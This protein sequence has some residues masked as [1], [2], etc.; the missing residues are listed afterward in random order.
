MKSLLSISLAITLLLS[1]NVQAEEL[2]MM[3]AQEQEEAWDFGLLWAVER[4]GGIVAAI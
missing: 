2:Q 1:I 3:S 4:T